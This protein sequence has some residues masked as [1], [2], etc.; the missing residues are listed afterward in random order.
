MKKRVVRVFLGSSPGS[1]LLSLGDEWVSVDLSG[2][3]AVRDPPV[4]EKLELLDEWASVFGVL[5]LNAKMLLIGIR[6]VETVAVIVGSGHRIVLVKSLAVVRL[7]ASRAYL[8]TSQTC[9]ELES[10]FLS[11]L[12]DFSFHYS[13]DYDFTHTLQ[14]CALGAMQLDRRFFWNAGAVEAFASKKLGYFTQCVTDAFVGAIEDERGVQYILVSRRSRRRQGTRF[15]VRGV[16]LLVRLFF[17]FFCFFI[18]TVG[19]GQRCEFC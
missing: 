1:C 10:G 15:L 17:L 5:T 6:S 7:G 2:V 19:T 16:D 3:T 8:L 13:P 9:S 4:A 14:R 11:F 12:N 18:N